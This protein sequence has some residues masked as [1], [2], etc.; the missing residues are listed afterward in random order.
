[1]G[2]VLLMIVNPLRRTD[3]DVVQDV[4]DKMEISPTEG[5]EVLI[6]M[7]QPNLDQ[8]KG[9]IW[10]GGLDTSSLPGSS[11]QARGRRRRECGA[12]IG[13]VRTLC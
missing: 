1:M 11:G 10:V 6:P 13:T 4:E 5:L 2:E 12:G 8:G 3:D 9:A 7:P